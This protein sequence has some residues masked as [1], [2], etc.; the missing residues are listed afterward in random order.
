MLVLCA[1]LSAAM[2]FLCMFSRQHCSNLDTKSVLHTL[3]LRASNQMLHLLWAISFILN[4]ICL[5]SLQNSGFVGHHQS[6]GCSCRAPAET[7][8][9]KLHRFYHLVQTIQG[10]CF[11]NSC[12]VILRWFVLLATKTPCQL[13][14]ALN[15]ED[16]ADSKAKSKESNRA[17]GVSYIPPPN[18]FWGPL[19]RPKAKHAQDVDIADEDES[20]FDDSAVQA[21]Q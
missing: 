15:F 19:A 21:S 13:L 12:I 6:L 18:S 5:R 4:L 11:Y 16:L 3:I 10:E 17:N 2:E 20:P 1:T 7:Q 14:Q 9:H 8:G